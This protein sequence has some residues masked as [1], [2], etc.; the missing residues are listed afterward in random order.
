MDGQDFTNTSNFEQNITWPAGAG[1]F[2]GEYGEWEQQDG[3]GYVLTSGNGWFQDTPMLILDDI[4]TTNG[5]TT[6]N[7]LID[8]P[9]NDAFI[10]TPRYL[11]AGHTESD[12]RVTFD[13][14]GIHV[15]KYPD[16]FVFPSDLYFVRDS[17]VQDT[18]GS[19]NYG[20]NAAL[21]TTVLDENTNNLKIYK[22]GVLIF[23]QDDMPSID[24]ETAMSNTGVYYGG[25]GSND[26]GFTVVGIPETGFQYIAPDE[27]VAYG[28]GNYWTGL[29][30]AMDRVI[31]G[32]GAVYSMITTIGVIVVWT[33]PES[34][35]PLWLNILLIK[36][37]ALAILY[38]AARLFRG[39]G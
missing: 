29:I 31:P 35:F 26:V 32:A 17:G 34:V 5:V 28:I 37:Q 6:V 39:G 33:L 20:Y 10:I 3:I 19:S 14:D 2:F 8:N 25:V 22:D 11:G 7:Y 38:L 18:S 4:I 27:E 23:D 36:T 21:F 1:A 12:I 16:Y 15:A 24:P 30:G 13:S 9:G